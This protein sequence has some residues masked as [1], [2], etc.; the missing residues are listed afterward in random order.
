MVFGLN[1]GELTKLK[2]RKS[3]C[4]IEVAILEKKI[5]G[6]KQLEDTS[7]EV[8][9][10]TIDWLRSVFSILYNTS[11]INDWTDFKNVDFNPRYIDIF[12]QYQDKIPEGKTYTFLEIPTT[13]VH[14]KFICKQTY[15]EWRKETYNGLRYRSNG[16]THP[17]TRTESYMKSKHAFQSGIIYLNGD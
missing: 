14:G 12:L 1:H 9:K 17:F 4:E 11:D 10:D 5:K 13:C 16:V 6:Y 3:H 15:S 8:Y 7:I 2:I